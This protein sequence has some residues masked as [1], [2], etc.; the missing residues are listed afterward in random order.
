MATLPL[1]EFL[2]YSA[3]G[4]GAQMVGGSLGMAYGVCSTTFLLTAGMPLV[5]ASAA[6]HASGLFTT[7]A[8][9]LSH[10]RFRNIDRFLLRH[11]LPAGMI[12][13]AAGAAL[14][15]RIPGR[16]IKVAVS[17]YLVLMGVLILR[18]AVRPSDPAASSPASRLVPMGL[19][20]GFLD[21]MG[22][23]GWG[24]FVASSLLAHGCPPRF[25]VGTV[26]LCK[27]FVNVAAS[28]VFFSLLGVP[29][30][31]AVAGLVSGGV[32]A[33]PIAAWACGR[34]PH[35]PMMFMAGI[36]VVGVSLRN[37]FRSLG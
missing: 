34:I 22:G 32:V 5:S 9:G 18:R 3:C 29:D 14:L 12:G 10:L 2:T 27:F 21:A 1:S 11:L 28:A 17:F 20:G 15:A 23:G 33:A 8:S 16:G 26:N 36:L 7:G 6:V 37:L 25:V 13:G 4:F 35:R 31:A 24:V 19:A 30:L